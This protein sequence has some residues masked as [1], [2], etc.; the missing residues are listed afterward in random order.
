VDA[1]VLTA[2]VV[3]PVGVE[4]AAGGEGAELEDSFCTF[5]PTPLT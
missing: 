2:E 1:F 3:E 5:E 4:V